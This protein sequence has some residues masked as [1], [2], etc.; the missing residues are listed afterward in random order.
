MA[1]EILGS[2]APQSLLAM[3]APFFTYP[4]ALINRGSFD[5]G[6]PVILKFSTALKV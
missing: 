5:I 4:K 2:N 6:S 1:S 3:A